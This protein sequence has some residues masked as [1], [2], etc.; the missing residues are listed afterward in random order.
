MRDN[1]LT[2]AQGVLDAAGCTCPTGEV[3]KGVYDERGR[4][5]EVPDWVVGDPGDLVAE[6]ED[7]GDRYEDCESSFNG[8]DYKNEETVDEESKNS[9]GSESETGRNKEKEKSIASRVKQ[10]AIKGRSRDRKLK[11][12]IDDTATDGDKGKSTKVRIRLSDR[13]GDIEVCV[14]AY[15]R[16]SVLV[17]MIREKAKVRD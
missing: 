2:T 7:E 13:V 12:K 10:S 6:E 15:E 4:L 5:Y 17:A 1:D 14:G 16:V 3:A 8:T 9:S 11:K